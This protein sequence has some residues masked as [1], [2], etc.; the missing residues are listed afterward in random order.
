MLHSGQKLFGFPAEPT[1]G[2]LALLSHYGEFFGGL[3][4]GHDRAQRG[5]RFTGHSRVVLKP[6]CGATK[7]APHE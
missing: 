2:M 5:L 3:S 1:S 4:N 7:L 6:D